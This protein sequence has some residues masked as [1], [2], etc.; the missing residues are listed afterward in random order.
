M[1]IDIILTMKISKK[2]DKETSLDK[3]RART[4]N[5]NN[6]RLKIRKQVYSNN[7]H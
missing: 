5:N 4:E 6:R 2:T 7:H 3:P 1:N